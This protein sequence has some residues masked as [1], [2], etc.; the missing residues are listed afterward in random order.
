MISIDKWIELYTEIFILPDDG[1]SSSIIFDPNPLF[2]WHEPIHGKHPLKKNL[3]EIWLSSR[4]LSSSKTQR[5]DPEHNVYYDLLVR[6]RV[7]VVN[8]EKNYNHFSQSKLN[9]FDPDNHING[10]L[11]DQLMFALV[12]IFE[13]NNKGIKTIV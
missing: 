4:C 7:Q 12:S 10:I 8:D 13:N 2:L 11:F 6:H 3:V 1:S 5:C 9:L